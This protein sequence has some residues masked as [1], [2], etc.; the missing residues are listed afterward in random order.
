LFLNE[1]DIYFS[2]DN[3]K[4]TAGIKNELLSNDIKLKNSVLKIFKINNYLPIDYKQ[5]K[6]FYCGWHNTYFITRK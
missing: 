5:I 4:G 6:E 2:G 1:I 3:S